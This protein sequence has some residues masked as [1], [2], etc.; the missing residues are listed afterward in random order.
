M[1]RLLLLI[2]TVLVVCV[3]AAPVNNA[4][5]TDYMFNWIL[6]WISSNKMIQ[7]NVIG[8]WGLFWYNDNGEMAERCFMTGIQGSRASFMGVN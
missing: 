7:C 2:I 8:L 6:W 5:M 3:Q 4:T 1:V